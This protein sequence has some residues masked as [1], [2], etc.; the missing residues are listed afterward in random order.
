M[1]V[2]GKPEHERFCQAVH[3]HLL[4]GKNRGESR[5][6][7]YM[8]TV[9]GTLA[10]DAAIGDQAA[11]AR[12]LAN[13]PHIKA[14]IQDIADR[15]AVLADLDRGWALVRLKQIAEANLHDY[16]APADEEGNR[17]FDLGAVKPEKMGLLAELSQDQVTETAGYGEEK[18]L[19][20]IRK[21]RLKLHDRIAAIN[22]ICR[23]EGWEKPQK[24][25]QT[26]AAGNDLPPMSEADR[27]RMIELIFTK[28]QPA[29]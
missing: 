1:G 14:R 16:L 8:E 17:F 11:N 18:T 13:Q 26:D 5:T 28:P 23:I 15:A 10:G 3:A 21:L 22:L 19:R 27:A 29:P 6:L 24:H 4:A 2:L 7:A 9:A 12:R 20:F 25:A